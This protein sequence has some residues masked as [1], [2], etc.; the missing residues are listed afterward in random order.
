MNTDHPR[1]PRNRGRLLL[2]TLVA[3]A[4]GSVWRM[5]Q[6]ARAYADLYHKWIGTP[7]H[8]ADRAPASTHAPRRLVAEGRL[9][10]RPGA[11]VTVG[12]QIPG[13]ILRLRV[14]ER[15]AVRVG[16]LIAELDPEEH[17]AAVAEAEARLAE[18]DADLP[19][20]ES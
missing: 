6:D 20:L 9:V 5:H 15:D 18:I 3:C 11:E 1:T 17:R 7:P 12:A 2:A 14:N 19:L 4:L 16:D 8:A 13:R 10:A